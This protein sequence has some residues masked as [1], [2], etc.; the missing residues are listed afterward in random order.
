MGA[1]EGISALIQIVNRVI[2]LIEKLG[3]Y[4]KEKNVEKWI[5]NLEKVVDDLEKAQTPE[6]KQNAA[7]NLVGLIRTLG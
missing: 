2:P 6:E 4:I 3:K 1:I 5:D 7:K